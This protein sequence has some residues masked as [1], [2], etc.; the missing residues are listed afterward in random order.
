[1]RVGT[2]QALA[3]DVAGPLRLDLELRYGTATVT[4]SYASRVV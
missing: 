2:I 1:V 4:N 3:P